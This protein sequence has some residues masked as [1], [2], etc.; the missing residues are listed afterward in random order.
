MRLFTFRQHP[1]S[2]VNSFRLINVK[3]SGL[4]ALNRDLKTPDSKGMQTL[5]TACI[6]EA[7][8]NDD[9]KKLLA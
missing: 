7:A 5:L 1:I 4:L 2:V 3:F 6:Y 8:Q 9:L